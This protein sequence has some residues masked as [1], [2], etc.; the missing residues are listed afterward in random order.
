MLP[1]KILAGV[2]LI[3]SAFVLSPKLVWGRTVYQEEISSQSNRMT[4]IK[5]WSGYGLNINFIPTGEVIKKVW[6]D[7]P[8]RITLTSDGQLCKQGTGQQCTNQGATVIHLKQINEIEFPNIPQSRT[9]ATLLTVI[10]QGESGRN[11]YQF[12]VKPAFGEPEYATVDVKPLPPMES[13]LDSTTP[14]PTPISNSFKDSN[15]LANGLYSGLQVATRAGAI[16]PESQQWK[17][18]N[19]LISLLRDGMNLEKATTRSK[20]PM[21]LFHQLLDWGKES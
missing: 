2:I 11:L 7:D 19:Y 12:K 3:F 6:L 17:K 4:E 13:P 10:T 5:V 9:G 21:S 1:Q 20:I 14:A 18:V 16:K 15:A 8:S